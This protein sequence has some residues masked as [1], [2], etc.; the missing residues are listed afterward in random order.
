MTDALHRGDPHHPD[1]L[2]EASTRAELT[3]SFDVCSNCRR[4]IDRC[5]VFPTLFDLVAEREG[6]GDLTPFEQDR[7]VGA[8]HHCGLCATACP[9]TAGSSISPGPDSSAD[10]GD[11]PIDI[12]RLMVRA[13]A[14]AVEAGHASRSSRR[15]TRTLGAADRLGALGVRFDSAANRIVDAEPG[16]LTRRLAERIS[17]VSA[18]RLL[19]PY[20]RERFSTWFRRRPRVTLGKRQSRVTVYPTCLVEYHEVG[21]GKDLVAVYERNGIECGLSGAGCCGAPSLHG[22]DVKRFRQIAER[23]VA[24]LATEVRDGNDLIVPQAACASVL[25]RAYPEHVSPELRA[26]AELV[27]GHVRDA[28]EYLLGVHQSGSARL[29]TDFTGDLPRSITYHAACHQRVDA[30][31]YAGRDLLRLTGVQVDLVQQCAGAGETWGLRP[32]NVDA[33][34]ARAAELV[35]R[36]DRDRVA[37]IVSE[38]HRAGLAIA[39]HSSADA[40]WTVAH[41]IQVLARAYGISDH[42]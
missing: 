20:A 4:C 18:V 14:M 7:L 6:A 38:C 16:S 11:E 31:R 29:D 8:C 28:A 1:Y 10:L 34:S 36:L 32:G 3:R 2:D 26:D 35:D 37:M 19:A 13:T 24:Q 17:G 23:N 12:P 21:I 41:P 33:A 42:V 22:G 25:R 30:D 27:A 40:E 15:A 9:Y 5:A 39:E